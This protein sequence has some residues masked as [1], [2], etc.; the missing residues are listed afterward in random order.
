MWRWS[1]SDGKWLWCQCVFSTYV[2]VIPT[3]DTT[4][5]IWICILH[6]CGG[7]P[8]FWAVNS[9][10][11]LYSPRMW[12]WS[13]SLTTL[14]ILSRVFS[15]Y[16]EVILSLTFILILAACILHVCGG[17]PKYDAMYYND[18]KYSPRMWRWSHFVDY[19]CHFL[20]VFSTYVEVI[21]PNQ[22]FVLDN[23]GILHV[24]GGDP[25]DIQADWKNIPYSPRMWRWSPFHHWK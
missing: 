23:D 11:N 2:E 7:D 22:K 6:V 14:I 1:P 21:L 3:R 5:T 13:S 12:R 24:C 20:S 19:K 9:N 4:V 10:I 8:E 25:P 17:D 18:L 15:T 16:V